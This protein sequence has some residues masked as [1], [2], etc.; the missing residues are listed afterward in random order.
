MDNKKSIGKIKSV[1]FFSDERKLLMMQ[2][3]AVSE[4]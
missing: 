3:R 1:Q 4:E 2:M